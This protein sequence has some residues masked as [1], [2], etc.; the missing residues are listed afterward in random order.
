MKNRFLLIF[1]SF[2]FSLHLFAFE[3]GG[4]IGT[5]LGFDISKFPSGERYSALKNSNKLSLW[6]KQNMDSEGRYNFFAQTSY[7]FKVNQI[8]SPKEKAV[9]VHIADVDLLK[10]SFFVPI[11]NKS[12]LEVELGRSGFSDITKI[13]SNQN[14]DGIFIKY[15]TPKFSGFWSFGYTGLLN[16]LT[17]FMDAENKSKRNDIYSLAPD[18]LSLVSFFGI[19]LG[20]YRHYLNIEYLGFFEPKAAGNLKTYLTLSASGIIVPRLFFITSFS[21]S[22]I[23]RNNIMR[24]GLLVNADLS[25]YFASYGAKLSFNTQWASGGKYAFESFTRTN[26]S[27]QFYSPYRNVW[28]MGVAASL[29]PVSGLYLEAVSNL[30]FNGD[31]SY[32]PF[33][34]G[35]EWK[36]ALDYT[37]L[38]DI[39]LGFSIGQYVPNSQKVLTHIEMKG[40]IAF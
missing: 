5:E 28:N 40:I 20:K 15:K 36:T 4:I 1:L 2:V 11:R 3:G 37:I 10:F 27:R 14:Y 38:H 34:R 24:G 33:Y 25:Y 17:V 19:P 23:R 13:I 39:T 22:F 30:I 26:I 31:K 9:P 8:L 6:L 18:Y 29:K 7:F 21:G 16:S 35:F 32:S 12:S